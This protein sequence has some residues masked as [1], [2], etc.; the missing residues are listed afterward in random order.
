MT[1]DQDKIEYEK[2][3]SKLVFDLKMN[4]P[5]GMVF[6]AR[7]TRTATEVGGVVQATKKISIKTAHERLGHLSEE[8]TR[9][10]AKQLGWTL[11]KGSLG[12]CESC[13]IGKAKQKRVKTSEPKEKSN[14]VNGRIYLDMS[15]IVNAKDKDQPMRPNWCLMVDEKTGYKTTSFHETKGGMVDTVCRKLSNWKDN[16]MAVE[17]IRMDN[18][19]ENKKL[20][21]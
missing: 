13:A 21:K 12:T 9:K 4:S 14:K 2:E 18:G 1:G 19:G 6:G 8:E 10:T 3:G 5:K 17:T 7:L 11:S 20:V 15:R 16:G